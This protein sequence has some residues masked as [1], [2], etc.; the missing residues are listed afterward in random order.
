MY[1][2]QPADERLGKSPGPLL[3]YV[4]D[5]VALLIEALGFLL[6]WGPWLGGN[7]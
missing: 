1:A 4:V 6:V 7:R 5:L 3:P 2:L